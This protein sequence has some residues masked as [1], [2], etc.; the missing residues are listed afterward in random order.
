MVEIKV[1]INELY[2]EYVLL[3]TPANAQLMTLPSFFFSLIEHALCFYSFL[4]IPLK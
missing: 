1:D 2:R 3:S 4:V